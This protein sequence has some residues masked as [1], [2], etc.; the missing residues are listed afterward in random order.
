MSLFRRITASCC[1]C[2]DRR[3]DPAANREANYRPAERPKPAIKDQQPR[4][5]KHASNASFM[6]DISTLP[7][8]S[9]RPSEINPLQDLINV[10]ERALELD[11]NVKRSLLEFIRA[12]NGE[13]LQSIITASNSEDP[14]KLSDQFIRATP[15]KIRDT[16]TLALIGFTLLSNPNFRIHAKPTK[17]KFDTV[18]TSKAH[19]TPIVQNILIA[20]QKLLAQCVT[21][22]SNSNSA[23]SPASSGF[24]ESEPHLAFASTRQPQQEARAAS[25]GSSDIQAESNGSSSTQSSSLNQ[26]WHYPAN[27]TEFQALHSDLHNNELATQ[28][29]FTLLNGNLPENDRAI[30][31]ANLN[32]HSPIQKATGELIA[33]TQT[34]NPDFMRAA[35]SD[36]QAQ[37]AIL[38]YY[39]QHRSQAEDPEHAT[40]A[41]MIMAALIANRNTLMWMVKFAFEELSPIASRFTNPN[42]NST[43]EIAGSF[44][45]LLGYL[46]ISSLPSNS[47]SS[48]P[49]SVA[50][51]TSPQSSETEDI[52]AAIPTAAITPDLTA[53]QER[54]P[55]LSR[56]ASADLFA[57]LTTEERINLAEQPTP[58]TANEPSGARRLH[59]KTSLTSVTEAEET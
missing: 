59:S 20:T 8:S 54:P 57:N 48:Q 51:T 3:P 50:T 7:A 33:S 58:D 6:S 12:L 13:A 46:R 14:T 49:A 40:Q 27:L 55:L 4:A 45:Y 11:D 19:T 24:T 26:L 39:Y 34:N 41:L 5:L 23:S 30:L 32:E 15:E 42:P 18:F 2:F 36:D 43:V 28:I 56:R 38:Y 53:S 31:S 47:G 10:V 1:P 25:R 9:A 22:T 44:A 21:P 52:E 29:C 37:L 16:P 17:Q 35:N